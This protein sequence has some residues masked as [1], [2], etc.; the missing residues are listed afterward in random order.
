MKNGLLFLMLLSFFLYS[1]EQEEV[2]DDLKETTYGDQILT[3]TEKS[4]ADF[5]VLSELGNADVPVNIVNTVSGKCLFMNSNKTV[6]LTNNKDDQNAKWS[7]N[8]RSIKYV[9]S[10]IT[11][12]APYYL[13]R[14]TLNGADNP[15]VALAMDPSSM[16]LTCKMQN[17][18]STEKDCFYIYGSKMGIGTPG[19]DYLQPQSKDKNSLVFNSTSNLSSWSVEPIGE[20]ELVKIEY[21]R[22]D[23]DDIIPSFIAAQYKIVDNGGDTTEESNMSFSYNIKETSNYSKT[24]GVTMSS[25]LNFQVGVPNL[26]GLNG[27]SL[28][29]G[30]TVGSQTSRTYMFG[31]TNDETLTISVSEKVSVPAHKK[32]KIEMGICHYYGTLTYVIT[33]RN[34]LTGKVFKMRGKWDGDCY[35]YTSVKITDITDGGNELIGQKIFV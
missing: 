10:L 19:K 29:M 23:I 22:T 21:V 5:D 32:Y 27:G 11:E 3:R 14:N 2:I 16:M 31:T 28:G 25:S 12:G 18:N 24:E 20:Y 35:A 1:C 30:V 15:M 13:M 34:P 4:I 26:S 17:I 33:M 6:S 7:F 8:G 9:G